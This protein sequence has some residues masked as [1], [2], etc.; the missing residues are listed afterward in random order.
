M[1]LINCV[2]EKTTLECRR[3]NITMSG[4]IRG[5]A[6]EPHSLR[7][8]QYDSTTHLTASLQFNL[9][10]TYSRIGCSRGAL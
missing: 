5:S 2:K 4:K 8:I 7:H 1:N 6:H 10:M 9:A 3:T